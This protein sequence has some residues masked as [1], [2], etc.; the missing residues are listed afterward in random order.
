MHIYFDTSALA[1]RYKTETDSGF[2]NQL[3]SSV[4]NNVIF[5]SKPFTLIEMA[6]TLRRVSTPSQLKSVWKRFTE[7]FEDIFVAVN[8]D[9][10]IGEHASKIALTSNCKALDAIHIASSAKLGTDTRFLTFDKQ[11]ARAAQVCGLRLLTPDN[12][13]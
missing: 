9:E 5:L 13:Q 12:Y 11:Q 10:E 4:P 8:F 7:E 2:V 6:S 3:V 1:K